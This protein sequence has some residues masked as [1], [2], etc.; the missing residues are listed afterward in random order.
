MILPGDLFVSKTQ[1][2]D[3]ESDLIV[4]EHGSNIEYRLDV[5]KDGKTANMVRKLFY[6]SISWSAISNLIAEAV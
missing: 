6:A 3:D 4:G 2:E 1:V 5:S